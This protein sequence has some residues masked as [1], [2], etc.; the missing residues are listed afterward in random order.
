MPT[1]EG[2]PISL[3]QTRDDLPKLFSEPGKVEEISPL[4]PGVTCKDHLCRPGG[5]SLSP[6]H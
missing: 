2:V 1:M 5:R 4:Q 6:S 3:T